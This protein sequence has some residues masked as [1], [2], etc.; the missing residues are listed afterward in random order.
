[1]PTQSQENAI[2]F[3]G[4]QLGVETTPG[5]AVSANK[6]LPCTNLE[7]FSIDIPTETFT[8]TGQKV[9]EDVVQGKGVSVANL[10]ASPISPNDIVYMLSSYL[11]QAVVTT[12][13][14]GTLSRD[15]LFV[16]RYNSPDT[17]QTFTFDQ[18]SFVGAGRAVFSVFNALKM[19]IDAGSVMSEMTGSVLARLVDMDG[20]YPSGYEVH[21]FTTT[22][23]VTA[24][25]FTI[26][27]DGD[28]TANIS[29][30]ATAV[31]IANAIALARGLPSGGVM[32]FGG[33]VNIAPVVVVYVDDFGSAV[34]A[35]TVNGASLIGGG[36]ITPT[37][38]QTG[39]AITILEKVP[40]GYKDWSIYIAEDLGDLP[41]DFSVSAGSASQLLRCNMADID[42]PA[43]NIANMTVDQSA[44]SFSAL[45]EQAIP[46]TIT[47]GHQLN[48]TGRNFFAG[49]KAG[50]KYY[51]RAVARG[52][53]IED[54]LYYGIQVT[55]CAKITAYSPGD[56]A[57]VYNTTMTMSM[58]RDDD[59]AGRSWL[60]VLVRNTLAAL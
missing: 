58:I 33:P 7:G 49:F 23:N 1:M 24:G 13:G 8:P 4:L 55:C 44:V 35:P 28:T 37:R 38:T 30:Q 17:L 26:T 39:V 20:V 56:A 29:Y 36:T 5:T 42:L 52:P 54:S 40:L 51:V 21:T 15:W 59:M 48:A 3:Q 2:I 50:T 31:A 11:D 45:V 18:G 14:G 6:R 12:P 19:R 47:V 27:V 60:E 16:P 57:G 53:L 41:A 32:G 22:G 46:G 10:A 43:K 34:G 9:A 25:V